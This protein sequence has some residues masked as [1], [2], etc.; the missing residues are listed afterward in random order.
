MSG[1]V[2]HG[3]DK[4]SSIFLLFSLLFKNIHKTWDDQ[5]KDGD[6][7]TILRFM[8]TGTGDIISQISE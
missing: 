7:K 8:E 5:N 3:L 4:K 2:P 1:V 6:T